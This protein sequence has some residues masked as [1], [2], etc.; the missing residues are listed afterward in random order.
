MNDKELRQSV[1]DEL[2]FDPSFDSAD[3][4]VAAENGV[5]TLNGHVRSYLEKIA[6]ERAAWR[7]KGVKAIAQNIQVRLA[8]AQKTNDDEIAQRAL[9]ILQWSA[10]VSKDSIQVRVQDGFITLTGKANWNYQRH[11]AESSVRRLNGV[12][13]VINDIKIDPIVTPGDIKE[14]ISS[15]LKRH[16]DVEAARINVEVSNGRVSITGSVDNWEER[17]AVERAAW[18]TPGVHMVED[19][20]RI[21]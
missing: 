21:A 17:R 15:A 2:D 5:V 13:G 9:N 16:A 7:V 12:K 20:L 11:A 3:I 6:V 18:A 10:P 4:G 19:H 14:R 8:M 1:I